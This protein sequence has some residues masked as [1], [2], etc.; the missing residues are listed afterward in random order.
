MTA[1]ADERK[2]HHTDMSGG[3]L[4]SNLESTLPLVKVETLH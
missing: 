1:T 4:P 3:K 2:R